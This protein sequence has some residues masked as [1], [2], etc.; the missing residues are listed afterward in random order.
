VTEHPVALAL[1]AM[2]AVALVWFLVQ[3]RKTA[4]TDIASI[5]D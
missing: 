4:A 2:S 5:E 1:L 3:G